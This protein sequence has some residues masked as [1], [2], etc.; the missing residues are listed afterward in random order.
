MKPVR[1][2]SSTLLSG[3]NEE[4]GDL[5]VGA[6]AANRAYECAG[7]VHAARAIEED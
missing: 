5:P 6:L 4:A 7:D 1:V 3:Y 2:L